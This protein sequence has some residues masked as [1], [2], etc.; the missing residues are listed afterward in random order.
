M[1]YWG[2]EMRVSSIG[3][4]NRSSHLGVLQEGPL[5]DYERR[6]EV[7]LGRDVNLSVRYLS[8][9]VLLLSR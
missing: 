1:P 9:D 2:A 7:D 8:T 6:P 5:S 4:L 3:L